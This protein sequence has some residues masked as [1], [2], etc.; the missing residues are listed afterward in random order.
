MKKVFFIPTPI[1]NL[2]D[3]TLRSIEILKYVDFIFAEDTR[4]TLKLLNHLNIKKPL[5]SYHKDNEKLLTQ[6]V[7]EHV[8]CGNKIG[9]VSD[10]GT[11]CISD[12][13]Q[14]L[15]KK[16]IE[17]DIPFEVL[18]GANAILPAL[19]MSGFDTSS[20]YFAGFLHHNV[21]KR[22]KEISELTRMKTT[23][24]LFESPHRLKSTLSILLLHFQP[25][26]AACREITKKFEQIIY[27]NSETDIKNLTLK[28][29]FVIVIDNNLC[30]EKSEDEPDYSEIEKL[31]KEGFSKRD[32]VK[33]MQIFGFKRNKVYNLLN[34]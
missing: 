34:K 22:K 23:I 1:G 21:S 26:V 6:K 12:P 31:K 19:V 10:A 2:G 3:I 18:P 27:I 33:I 13:G 29:E 14:F 25:P 11:P 32:I 8:K 5:K 15:V 16:L 9:I 28:G 30:S 7:L 17:N 4:N 24:I 20:F